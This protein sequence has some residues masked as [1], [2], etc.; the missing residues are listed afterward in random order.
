MSSL[1]WIYWLVLLLINTGVV[2]PHTCCSPPVYL[3]EIPKADVIGRA[4]S[5]PNPN[6]SQSRLQHTTNLHCQYF[7]QRRDR[8]KL[9]CFHHFKYHHWGELQ[10]KT[11]T[12]NLGQKVIVMC[13]LDWILSSPFKTTEEGCMVKTELTALS[14]F[15]VKA[16]IGTFK[17]KKKHATSSISSEHTGK[18][19]I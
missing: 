15:I 4:P 16:K 12:R 6:I 19:Y 13:T 2:L 9:F 14:H 5:S 17:K 18:G 1:M 8:A 10:H 7:L 3:G 11:E